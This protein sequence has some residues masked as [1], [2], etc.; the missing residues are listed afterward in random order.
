MH[1]NIEKKLLYISWS[2][3]IKTSSPIRR[4]P[5]PKIVG[6]DSTNEMWVAALFVKPLNRE[7]VMQQ[8]D[9]EAPGI[10]AKDC[11]NPI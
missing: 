10:T 2:L 7:P 1:K 5:E 11:Q 4:T 3:G 8:P 6:I 9:L